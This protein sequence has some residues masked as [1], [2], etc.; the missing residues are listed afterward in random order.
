[1]LDNGENWGLE[2]SGEDWSLDTFLVGS[3]PTGKGQC[4]LTIIPSVRGLSMKTW[5]W[6][7]TW[8]EQIVKG[9]GGIR[10]AEA[11][12]GT[13]HMSGEWEEGGCGRGLPF[14]PGWVLPSPSGILFSKAFPTGF[15]DMDSWASTRTSFPIHD[16]IQKIRQYLEFFI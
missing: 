1:M 12:R 4:S 11:E 10:K 7:S 13:W 16:E 3:Q 2:K 14:L 8:E 15:Y 6:K 9:M 5:V